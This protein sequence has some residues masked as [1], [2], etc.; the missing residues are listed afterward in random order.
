MKTYL[1]NN[2]VALDQQINTLLGGSPD[3]TLSARAYR[4][5]QQGKTF[6][7]FFRPAIDA[8][9]F[10]DHDHCRNAYNAEFHK[11]QLPEDYRA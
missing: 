3:E 4:T 6:G 7:K 8:L 1:L 11:L 9:F 2:V 5:E 10:F